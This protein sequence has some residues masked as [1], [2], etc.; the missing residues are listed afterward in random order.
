M[1]DRIHDFLDGDLPREGLT[2]PERARLAA[3]EAAV[4]EV[5]GPLRAAAPPD[6]ARRVMERLPEMEP[7]PSA[8]GRISAAWG[9][10]AGWLWSPR[11][12]T[13][14]IPFRPGLALAGACAAA[15]LALQLPLPLPR[16]PV[17]GV[18]VQAAD[19]APPLYV[20][21]R[22]EAPGASQVALAGSFTK[23]EPAYE[24]RETAPGVWSA[25]VPLTPGVH[26]YVF[27]VDGAEW[28][29]DP[30]AP[31]VQDPFGGTNSRLFLPVPERS[32]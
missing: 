6:L 29:A 3:L 2:F 5:A 24:L 31:R 16:T 20:Q 23:W 25:L 9:R 8:A 14:T 22:L 11:E 4:D 17:P 30:G 10:A 7:A 27:V 21:F 26:D 28:V 1:S 18:A 32:V 13:L 19:E 15:F 12:L